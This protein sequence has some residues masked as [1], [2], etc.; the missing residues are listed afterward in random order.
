MTR[1]LKILFFGTPEPASEI[2]ETLIE[3]DHEIVGVVTQPDKRRGRG[4]TL[5]PT[6]VKERAIQSNIEIFEPASK[7][8]LIECVERVQA[9]VGVVVAYGRILPK[10]VLDHFEFGCINVHYSV[11]PRWRGAAPV[12]R[13]ILSG[14]SSSGV[15][16]MKM[17]EGLDT[18]GVYAFRQVDILPQTNSI[19]LFRSLNAIAG[20]LLTVVLNHLPSQ[21]PISQTGEVTYAHKLE[22]YDFFFD[23]T[24]SVVDIDRKVR[25]GAGLKGAW[26]NLDGEKF[27]IASVSLPSMKQ[28]EKETLIGTIDRTGKFVGCDGS[29]IFKTVQVAGKTVMDFSSWANGIPVEKFPIRLDA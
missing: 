18:G 17:D 5:L 27:R 21:K 8:E 28:Q 4:K 9:D 13:A 26:T 11:L 10:L 25:A 3:S 29:L 2:L 20:D 1:V 12:E 23:S 6:P 14:D 7:Q 16:I 19:S 24:T 22:P 15:S